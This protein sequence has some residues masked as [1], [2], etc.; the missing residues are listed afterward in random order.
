[1]EAF[2][3]ETSIDKEKLRAVI[4]N[5]QRNGYCI[6]DQEFEPDLRSI[7]IPVV[8]ASGRAIAALNV[9]AQATRTGKK[10][11]LDDFLPVLKDAALKM[12][13]LLIG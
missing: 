1:M 8:N 7:A 9:S 13:P 11:M 6:V 3:H 5:V 2:N 10:Q 4:E 12:R